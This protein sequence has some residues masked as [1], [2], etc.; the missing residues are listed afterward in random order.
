VID[1]DFVYLDKAEESLEGAESELVNGRFNNCANRCYYACFLAAIH[2]LLRAGIRA[3]GPQWSHEFV[4]GQFVGQLINRQKRYPS[5]L[6]DVL[7]RNLELRVSADYRRDRVTRTQ[8]S[9][10]LQRTRTLV[11]A[12][13]GNR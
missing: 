3:P 10:A 13:Q 11:E 4:Q 1:L 8:A 9:R 12:V 2:A 6:R 7:A 5:E